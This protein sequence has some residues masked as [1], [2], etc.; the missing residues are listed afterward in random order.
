M[1]IQYTSAGHGQTWC[2]VWLT[3][4]KQRW[5]SNELIDWVGFNVP[6]KHIIGHIGEGFYGSNK[7]TNSVKALKEVVVLRIGLQSHQVHFTMLQYYTCMQYTIIHIIHAKMNLSTVK[8][9]L[10]DKTQSRELLG[11]FIICVH[12]TLHNCCTQ[13]CTEQTW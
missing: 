12:H 10:W 11:L 4:V 2:K 6:T 5:C 1:Y 13:C 9:A 3:F 7:P 8:W